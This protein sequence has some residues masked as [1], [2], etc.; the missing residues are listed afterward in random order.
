MVITC[1]SEEKVR[2]KTVSQAY[3][4]MKE[5][6]EGLPASVGGTLK[7][8]MERL[9]VT[10]EDLESLSGV[11]ERTIKN[12]RSNNCPRLEM[13]YFIAI[14]I[15]PK[16]E[17]HFNQRRCRLNAPNRCKDIR[18]CRCVLTHKNDR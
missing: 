8:H 14:C 11:S 15:G 16:L 5:V 9:D 7:A 6:I 12:I 18:G 17:P 3:P 10:I 2:K 4:E 1:G 13:R